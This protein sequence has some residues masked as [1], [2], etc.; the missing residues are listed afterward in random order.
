MHAQLR[1]YAGLILAGVLVLALTPLGVV[2]QEE[3]EKEPTA[4]VDGLLLFY[5]GLPFADATVIFKADKGDFETQVYTDGDGK[6]FLENLPGK[7]RYTVFI[8]M[9]NQD[10]FELQ[11][12]R[13]KAGETTEV[14]VDLKA[15]AKKQGHELTE[16][17]AADFRKSLED[18]KTGKRMMV[19]F[20]QG[21]AFLKQEQ[22]SQAVTELEAAAR[23]DSSQ[24][25][26]FSNLARAY[27]GAN[28]YDKGIGAYQRAIELAPGDG[29][30]YNNLGQLY[31]KA[32]NVDKGIESFGKA[33]DITPE[34]AGMFYYNIGVTLFNADRLE[35]A[36]APFQK[37]VELEP[38]R[39]EAHYFLG[40]CRFRN[41]D[42]VN[43]KPLPGT[44]EAFE[45]YLKLEPKGR[46]AAEAKQTIESIKTTFKQ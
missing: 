36:I 18:R 16:E 25:A 41:A 13:V 9:D 12:V 40:V 33:A 7:T 20:D 21:V 30:L 17:E 15:E 8:L 6:F 43:M 14:I 45:T 3:E 24:V 44:V 1:K 29:G 22:Y 5:D 4:T 39:A 11:K 42:W 38:Q 35:E 46:F 31:L 19:R 27:D 32:G 10:L 37:T 2:A 23:L 28:Q 34:K 26:V